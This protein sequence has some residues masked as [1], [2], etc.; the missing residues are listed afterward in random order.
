MFSMFW[1]QTFVIFAGFF[2]KWLLVLHWHS[3]EI[4]SERTRSK[5]QFSAGHLFV[6]KVSH[7]PDVYLTQCAHT[8]IALE[9]KNSG[10]KTL[11]CF[12]TSRKRK[13]KQDNF[14]AWQENTNPPLEKHKRLLFDRDC[15]TQ[16]KGVQGSRGSWKDDSNDGSK[17]K[18]EWHLENKT[19]PRAFSHIIENISLWSVF[20]PLPSRGLT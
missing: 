14:W 16:N 8:I 20:C 19:M 12:I 13:K 10:V 15:F 1:L 9:R 3:T 17:S 18:R 5:T 6:S 7:L 2:F 11:T 4:Q